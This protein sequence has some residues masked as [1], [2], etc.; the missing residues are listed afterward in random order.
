[1]PKFMKRF[2]MKIR[3]KMGKPPFS[4]YTAS[5]RDIRHEFDQTYSYA[6][7]IP[8]GLHFRPGHFAHLLPPKTQLAPGMAHHM[9]VASTME[10]GEM[11]FSMDLSSN[12][13]YKETYRKAEIGNWVQMFKLVGKFTLDEV[14]DDAHILFIAG[15]IGITPIRSL[16]RHLKQSGS[17]IQWNLLHVGRNFLYRSE[18]EADYPAHKLHFTGREGIDAGIAESLPKDQLS[19]KTWC[20]I[21]G[22]H[23]FVESL[24]QRAIAYGVPVERIKTE[25]FDH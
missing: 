23:G 9:S 2:I 20:F 6:L 13:P 17:T 14:E 1:M 25:D 8:E 24:T 11:L 18:F 22:S 4:V 12:S 3:I 16:I 5:I 7:N 15:G 10:D 19:E 21:S